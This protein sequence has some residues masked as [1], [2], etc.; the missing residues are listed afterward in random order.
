M[1]ELTVIILLG[2]IGWFWYSSVQARDTAIIAARIRCESRGLVLLDQT[3]SLTKI[4]LRRDRKG[5]MRFER[6]YQFE[7]S[8]NGDNRFEGMITLHSGHITQFSIEIPPIHNI[9]D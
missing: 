3:I 6:K 5:E 1:D 9:E 2:V 4:R 8:S 7:F